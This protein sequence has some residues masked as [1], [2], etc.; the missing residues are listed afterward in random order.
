ML[1]AGWSP[2]APDIMDRK[3]LMR[4]PT[5]E[6]L[7][8]VIAVVA[9]WCYKTVR[10]GGDS[11]SIGLWAAGSALLLFSILT[12]VGALSAVALVPIAAALLLLATRSPR[13][14]ATVLRRLKTGHGG[15]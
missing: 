2:P 13:S 1:W 14:P 8:V 15:P 11:F 6:I 10:A 5:V 9:L 3:C 12:S 7:L 4:F